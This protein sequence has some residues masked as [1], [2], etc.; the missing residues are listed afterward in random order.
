MT[1]IEVAKKQAA[2]KLPAIEKTH[3]SVKPM[4]VPV[5]GENMEV[6]EFAIAYLRPMSKPLIGQ[7]MMLDRTN[8]LA[9]QEVV[10]RGLVIADISDPRVL[11]DTNH[12]GIFMNAIATLM[13]SPIMAQYAGQLGN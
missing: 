13:S 2:E 10:L 4:Y 5:V 3:G 9:A 8:P 7:Y 1:P 12:L 6:E 11:D